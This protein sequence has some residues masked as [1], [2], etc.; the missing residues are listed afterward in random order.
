MLNT[1]EISTTFTCPFH[2][3]ASSSIRKTHPI[4]LFIAQNEGSFP[5]KHHHTT[6]V[7]LHLSTQYN[8]YS[9]WPLYFLLTYNNC[10]T[11][12]TGYNT[13]RYIRICINYF[14][15][16]TCSCGSASSYELHFPFIL[17]NIVQSYSHLFGNSAIV[18][19]LGKHYLHINCTDTST[20]QSQVQIQFI[21]LY[22]ILSSHFNY[23]RPFL[24]CG[25]VH[26]PSLCKRHQR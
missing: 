16:Y 13:I 26:F 25:S 11:A 9:S 2:S 22:N 15:V 24:H 1:Y 7:L 14:C 23:Q 3:L 4:I 17:S 20:N 8:I 10:G 5:T 18:F 19:H 6:P 21:L 12:I